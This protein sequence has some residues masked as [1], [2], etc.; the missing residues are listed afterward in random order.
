VRRRDREVK[1]TG[2]VLEILREC[3]CCRVALNDGGWPYIVP[4]SYGFEFDGGA[5]RL[6]FHCAKQGKK[7]ELMARDGR[8]AF[9]L[10]CGH[11]LERG[12]AAC[13]YSYFYSSVMGRGTLSAV[14][15]PAE[16]G[17][18]A[19]YHGALH[20]PRG[21]G[22]RRPLV[23]RGAA[24]APR[25]HRVELQRKPALKNSKPVFFCKRKRVSSF[26]KE[27]TGDGQS[28]RRFRGADFRPPAARVSECKSL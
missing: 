15:D 19:A 17:G 4:L 8:A 7:L 3:D 20:R 5:L 12:E 11:A 16:R 25:R 1:D 10:D 13:D 18:A 27:N 23:R 21:L 28:P 26:P 24:P 9:E 6:Y 2:R 22:L 14:S